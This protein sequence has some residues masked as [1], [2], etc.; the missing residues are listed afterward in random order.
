[1]TIHVNAYTLG[2]TLCVLSLCVLF[3]LLPIVDSACGKKQV[4]KTSE[5]SDAAAIT[6][7]VGMFFLIFSFGLILGAW[8]GG[9]S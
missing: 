3:V 9:G 5:P 7:G 6:F 8:I 1:M 4:R 2:A